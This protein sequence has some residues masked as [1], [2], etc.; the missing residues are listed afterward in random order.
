M[1]KEC[2]CNKIFPFIVISDRYSHFQMKSATRAL[3]RCY[4]TRVH[5]IHVRNVIGPTGHWVCGGPDK[6]Q[7]ETL[8]SMIIILISVMQYIV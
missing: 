4:I 3:T 2:Y 5:A 6:A 8:K 1:N 7:Y